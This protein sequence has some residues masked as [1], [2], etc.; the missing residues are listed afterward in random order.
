MTSAEV[1]NVVNRY[2]TVLELAT[3]AGMLAI[4]NGY[5]PA[6]IAV[7]EEAILIAV[8][9]QVR[10]GTYCDDNGLEVGF[11]SLA[12]F[13]PKVEA[14]LINRMFGAAPPKLDV[15]D[16]DSVRRAL[17]Y[18][19][20]R[21]GPEFEDALQRFQR[22]NAEMESR[23]AR[24]GQAIAGFRASLAREGQKTGGLM[25]RLFGK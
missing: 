10:A 20:T 18:A 22:I 1:E 2:G 17:E 21:Q 4:D 8:L 9:E 23:R 14:E 6:P 5:L 25:A 15:G 11:M 16:S 3:K 12:E 13:V 7:I 19:E 24:F